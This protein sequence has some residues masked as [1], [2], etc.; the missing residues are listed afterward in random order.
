MVD[1]HWLPIE[2]RRRFEVLCLVYKALHGLATAYLSNTLA[3]YEPPRKPQSNEQELLVVLKVRTDKY[4]GRAFS[5]SA[6]YLYN[7]LP[8]EIHQ[9][10]SLNVII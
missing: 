2:F 6:P 5:Y 9:T 4:G 3:H 7:T 1:L 8:N 10:T